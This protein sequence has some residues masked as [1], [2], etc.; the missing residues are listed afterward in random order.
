[1][2][3][4]KKMTGKAGEVVGKAV[5]RRTILKTA[6]A[7]AAL[8]GAGFLGRSASAQDAGGNEALAN[9]A[10]E[11]AQESAECLAHCIREFN[12][13]DT[14][15]AKCASLVVETQ[16]ACTALAGLA[17]HNSVVIK[18]IAS[19]CIKT[20]TACEKECRRHA[21]HHDECKECADSCLAC[22]AACE[23]ILK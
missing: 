1:M 14:M 3:D 16:I 8:G 7:M 20:C 18:D 6:G 13:E 2:A 12:K 17:T 10:A 4:E 5:D 15:L 21:S 19:L 9:A 23:D 11:C 22:I